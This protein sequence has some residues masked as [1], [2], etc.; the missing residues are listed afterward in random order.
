M[1]TPDNLA[2]DGLADRIR[3]RALRNLLSKNAMLDDQDYESSQIIHK[4]QRNVFDD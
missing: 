4:I 2:A 3:Q 1:C